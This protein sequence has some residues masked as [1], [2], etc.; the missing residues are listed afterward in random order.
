MQANELRIGNW[1]EQ[2]TGVGEVDVIYPDAIKL[3]SRSMGYSPNQ[4][5]PV[6]LT[7]DWLV[8]YGAVK[9]AELKYIHGEFTLNYLPSYKY[10]YVTR[11]GEYC[12]KVEY[13]H[14]WQN[15]YFA[16]TGKEL[17]IKL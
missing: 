7:E 11:Y 12:S 2:P 1:V 6:I 16:L 9:K 5:N 17:E 10:W 3:K 13:V 14:E 15:L 8:K 4:T